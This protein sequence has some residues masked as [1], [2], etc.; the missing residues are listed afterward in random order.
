MSQDPLHLV[1]KLEALLIIQ[2]QE[3]TR[4]RCKLLPLLT[5][6]IDA[7]EC[8]YP[9]VAHERITSVLHILNKKDS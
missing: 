1:D 7:L 5:D 9:D 3:A 8:N 6:A 4:L 2:E